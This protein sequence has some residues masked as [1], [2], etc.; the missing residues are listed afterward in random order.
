MFFVSFGVGKWDKDT[1][2][3]M[4]EKFKGYVQQ[5][6]FKRK[7]HVYS[8]G[9]DDYKFVLP[10][11]FNEDCLCYGQKVKSKNGK[12]L[13]QPILRKVYGNPN[14]N[15]IETNTNESFNS[16]LRGKLARLVRKTKSHSK[17]KTE[18]ENILYL[19]QFYWNFMHESKKK[20]TPAI[21]ER[22]TAKLWTWGNF[23]HT[24]L[25]YLN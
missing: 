24:K 3:L 13:E 2:R 14:W 19:F 17:N 6:S 18:L 10:E 8:D 4:F 25:R 12:K 16:I 15:D 21:M 1:L 20:V 11:Y 23:L 22:Q 9:N 7:L 5:P